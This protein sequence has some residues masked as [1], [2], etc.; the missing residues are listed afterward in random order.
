M[1]RNSYYLLALLSAPAVLPAEA[2][3]EPVIRTDKPKVDVVF[4]LDTTGS[5]GGL[6]QAA[7][8]KIWAIANTLT[9]TRPTPEIRMGLIG[10]RDRGDSYVTT[11]SDLSPNLDSVYGSLMG[12]SAD[13]G[14]D[15][16][17]SVNQALHEAVTR[18]SWRPDPDTYKVVF[19]VGDAPPHMDYQDDIKYTETVALANR[20]GIV[21][22]TIQCGSDPGTRPVW[23]DIAGRAEGRYFQVGQGGDAVAVATPYDAELAKLSAELDATR[24]PYGS[25]GERAE[26]SKRFA[27]ADEIRAAAPASAL[28]GRAELNAKEAGSANLLGEKELIRD[29]AEGRVDLDALKEE[30]LPEPLKALS[31]PERAKRVGEH[32][33]KRRALRARIGALSERRQAHIAEEVKKAPAAEGSLDAKLYSAIKDQAAAQG[34]RYDQGPAY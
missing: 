2:A 23:Q 15:G 8:E 32:E 11:M 25:E 3:V 9:Q 33:E 18:A 30:D 5:M 12:Y 34:I 24:L 10:Y 14:G 29:V 26:Q 22:N 13:G 6:I 27:V 20:R 21:V 19:L 31:K 1:K 16:P 4:V 28:A 17:E 7:K